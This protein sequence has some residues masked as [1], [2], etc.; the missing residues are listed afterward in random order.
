M[1]AGIYPAIVID[2][3]GCMDTLAFDMSVYA[4]DQI[5]PNVASVFNWNGFDIECNGQSNGAIESNPTGGTVVLPT[6]Y[7]YSWINANG[8]NVGTQA[9]VPN[10]PAGIYTVT[11]TDN[12]A[13]SESTLL[14]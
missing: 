8:L 12:N 11:V 7:T 3:N 2:A 4:P 5:N 1:G 10:V 6:D 9:V 13:C 14:F